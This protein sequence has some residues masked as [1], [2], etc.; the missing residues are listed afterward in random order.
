MSNGYC[1]KMYL[2]SSGK[3]MKNTLST[4]KDEYQ[5]CI[6]AWQP[7]YEPEPYLE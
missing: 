7:Y 2:N 4:V 6:R 3:W 5:Y 1:E